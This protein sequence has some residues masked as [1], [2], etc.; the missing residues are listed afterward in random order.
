MADGIFRVVGEDCDTIDFTYFLNHE[1]YRL[2]IRKSGRPVAL[3]F[4]PFGFRY[5][6]RF[7]RHF[8]TVKISPVTAK[9]K[10]EYDKRS[11]GLAGTC[12]TH[13]I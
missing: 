7:A 8:L 9:K 11:T 12:S 5:K 10:N 2:E 6:R 4:L 3:P 1:T 13:T